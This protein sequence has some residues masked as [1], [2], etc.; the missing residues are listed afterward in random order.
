M[1]ELI[2]KLFLYLNN[3]PWTKPVAI[4]VCFVDLAV[5]ALSWITG[6]DIPPNATQLG[7]W[8][9]GAIFG[10]AAGKS[11]YEGTRRSGHGEDDPKD[12]PEDD[13]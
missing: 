7:I 1:K 10:I 8:F 6:R 5:F 4:I 13:I 3:L 2:N 11:V 9:G 12:G